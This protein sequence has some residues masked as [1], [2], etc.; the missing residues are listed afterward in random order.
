MRLKSLI[1]NLII[2]CL[3]MTIASANSPKLWKV[4]N[5]FLTPKCFTHEWISSDNLKAVNEHYSKRFPRMK[6]LN[7]QKL[8]LTTRNTY[9]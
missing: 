5:K 4:G 7:F 1:P 3:L 8:D 9:L 2:F 6:S